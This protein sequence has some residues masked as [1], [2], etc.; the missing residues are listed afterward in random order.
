MNHRVRAFVVTPRVKRERNKGTTF[1]IM[2]L[3][4]SLSYPKIVYRTEDF[5]LESWS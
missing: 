1:K 2:V 4:R 3:R 5:L